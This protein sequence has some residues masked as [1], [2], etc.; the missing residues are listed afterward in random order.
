[1]RMEPEHIDAAQLIVDLLTSRR[2]EPGTVDELQRSHLAIV[3]HFLE[4]GPCRAVR[5]R[6]GPREVMPQDQCCDRLRALI[7]A[8]GMVAR[9]IVRDDGSHGPAV[10]PA[11]PVPGRPHFRCPACRAT[12]YNPTDI[13]EGYCGNCHAFTRARS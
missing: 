3:G 6:L 11:A 4:C 5:D 8:Y 7:I 9:T 1:M 13:A 12:S 2:V 10:L